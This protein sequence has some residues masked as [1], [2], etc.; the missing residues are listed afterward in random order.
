MRGTLWSKPLE[1]LI[2]YGA[3]LTLWG[4][5]TMS[6]SSN[7]RK[8]HSGVKKTHLKKTPQGSVHHN[9]SVTQTDNSQTKVPS[10]EKIFMSV[11]VKFSSGGDLW[12]K[13]HNT[14]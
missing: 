10:R 9:L 8:Q 12:L 6:S 13:E 1:L 11:I 7:G 2:H 5:P 4:Y 3:L 14:K